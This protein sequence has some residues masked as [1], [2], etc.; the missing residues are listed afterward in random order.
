MSQVVEELNL[1][2]LDSICT[3]LI[4]RL[5]LRRSCCLRV[6]VVTVSAEDLDNDSLK[7][8]VESSTKEH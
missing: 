2:G 7:V 1:V 6:L 5:V 4:L 3:N 8:L